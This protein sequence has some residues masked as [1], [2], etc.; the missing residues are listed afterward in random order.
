MYSV[1][2]TERLSFTVMINSNFELDLSTVEFINVINL[3]YISN[4]K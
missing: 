2:W 1:K 3:Q 4:E